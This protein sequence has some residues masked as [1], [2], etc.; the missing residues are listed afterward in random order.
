MKTIRLKTIS[1][2]FLYTLLL[3]VC[4]T[5]CD[6]MEAESDYNKRSWEIKKLNMELDYL[7]RF[8]RLKSDIEFE[9]KIAKIDSLIANY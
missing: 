6:S 3:V 1:K 7:E 4:L 2:Y 8:Y 5:S 9:Q